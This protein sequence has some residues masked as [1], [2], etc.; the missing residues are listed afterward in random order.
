VKAIFQARR[1]NVVPIRDV[2]I[3]LGDNSVL[4][5]LERY[6]ER[7]PCIKGVAIGVICVTKISIESG[8][9][10]HEGDGTETQTCLE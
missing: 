1:A 8:A 5:A 10:R 3:T 2:Q 4:V 9:T 6:G 7:V